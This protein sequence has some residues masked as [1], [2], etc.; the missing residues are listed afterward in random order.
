MNDALAGVEFLRKRFDTVGVIGHSEGGTIALMLAAAQKVDFV[1][2]LAGMV[3]SGAETLIM[4]NN[5]ALA[6]AGFS[7]E[8]ID[9]YCKVLSDA[10]DVKVK[11]G[12]MP[13]IENYDLPDVLKQN[14]LSVLNMIQMPYMHHFLTLD[15]RPLLGKITCPVLALNGT[16][17]IQVANAYNLGA[18]RSGLPFNV[19]NRVESVE[20][21]NHLFQSCKT[22]AV[23]EYR[24]IEE[25]IMPEVL[26]MLADWISHVALE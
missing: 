17:D 3:I 25:T 6:E 8:V 7:Q 9:T 13:R 12:S 15:M 5:T 20:G 22:G 16:K 21:A 18:L 14:F 26:K 19:K 2:S 1:V 11:G 4:Q 23:S 24:E 10:F